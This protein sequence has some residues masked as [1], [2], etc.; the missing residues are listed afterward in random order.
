[1]YKKPSDSITKEPSNY[2]V[3]ALTITADATKANHLIYIVMLNYMFAV[4]M[5]KIIVI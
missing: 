5:T 2:K 3:A 4:L 1:M